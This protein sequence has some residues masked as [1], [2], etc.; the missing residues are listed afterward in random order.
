MAYVDRSSNTR[1]TGTAIAVAA[2]QAGVIYAVA[3]G[4][5]VTFTAPKPK[6]NSQGE[7]VEITPTVPEKVEKKTAVEPE[8]QTASRDR[9][10]VVET[11]LVPPKTDDFADDTGFTGTVVGKDDGFVKVPEPPQVLP[12]SFTPRLAKPR[13]APGSWAT[14]N[15]YPARDLREGNQGVTG[16]RLSIGTN[17]NVLSC[18]IT[19]SSGFPSLDRTAC[20]KITRRARFD[21]ATDGY[22]NKVAGTYTNNIRWEIPD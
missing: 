18:E 16:F 22:G 17:G 3:T 11:D 12:P 5:A 15:D 21:P 20:E 7:H 9:V 2:I 4:L 6:P 13:N 19:R 8:T 10:T 14:A 1:R